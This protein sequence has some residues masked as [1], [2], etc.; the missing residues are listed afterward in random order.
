MPEDSSYQSGFTYIYISL[1]VI[2]ILTVCPRIGILSQ[3]VAYFRKLLRNTPFQ[4][5]LQ[6]YKRLIKYRLVIHLV[7]IYIF[8]LYHLYVDDSNIT[9]TQSP[10]GSR[11]RTRRFIHSFVHKMQGTRATQGY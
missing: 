11:L 7:F 5:I 3:N 6:I 9:W 10:Y 8:I 2:S 4:S 1:L